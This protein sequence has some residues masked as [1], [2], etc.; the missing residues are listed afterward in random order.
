MTG[1]GGSVADLGRLTNGDGCPNLGRLSNGD[2]CPGWGGVSN[3]DDRPGVNGESKMDDG[4]RGVFT[5]V[6]GWAW[7][8]VSASSSSFS[9]LDGSLLMACGVSVFLEVSLWLI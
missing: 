8:C 6:V 9:L 5:S 7:L 4:L 1:A 2:G 3:I